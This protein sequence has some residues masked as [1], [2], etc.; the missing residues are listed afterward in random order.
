M[1][2]H[3]EPSAGSGLL[4]RSHHDPSA[5]DCVTHACHT[6]YRVW[7]GQGT[8]SVYLGGQEGLPGTVHSHTLGTRGW[9][10]HRY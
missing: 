1:D 7:D 8:E 3:H 9:Y 6:D 4:D 10:G 5:S 2:G